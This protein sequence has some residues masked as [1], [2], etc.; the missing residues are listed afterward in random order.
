MLSKRQIFPIASLFFATVI[1]G[2][3]LLDHLQ[4]KTFEGEVR[5]RAELVSNFGKAYRTYA[6]EKLRTEVQEHTDETIFKAMSFKK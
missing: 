4:R 2:A 1:G 5:N 6:K 3:F